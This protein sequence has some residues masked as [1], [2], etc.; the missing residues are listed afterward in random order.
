MSTHDSTTPDAI[1]DAEIEVSTAEIF[2]P[3]HVAHQDTEP[4][5]AEIRSND[6]PALAGV[7]LHHWSITA[8]T[9]V[10]SNP[11]ADQEDP[12][13]LTARRALNEAITAIREDAPGMA[14]DALDTVSAYLKV[15]A[16]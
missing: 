13:A 6:A 11:D 16:L 9:T 4:I 2:G 8:H 10:F 1:L 7:P 3:L 14:L 12:D 15:D 5:R